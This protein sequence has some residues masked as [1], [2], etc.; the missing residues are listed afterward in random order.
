MERVSIHV[1]ADKAHIEGMMKQSVIRGTYW[2]KYY[3]Y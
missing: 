1:I 2:V 3:Y